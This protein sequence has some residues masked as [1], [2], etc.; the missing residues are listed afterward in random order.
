MNE[1]L[2]KL[3]FSIIYD[4]ITPD[5]ET[6]LI[7]NFKV[8]SFKKNTKSRNSIQRF[9]SNV[10]YKG[11]LVSKTIPEYF[12]FLLDKL[13]DQSLVAV[14]PESVTINEYLA[15]QGITPHIDSKGSGEVITVLSLLSS[16]EMVLSNKKLQ[17][18]VELP[19]RCL[20]QMRDE[21]RHIWQHSV[22]PVAST[23]YSIVFRCSN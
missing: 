2:A 6:E 16:A 4:F 22:K 15:G 10:P 20:C 1:E 3:G 11:S 9:G 13:I 14:K 19:P 18:T 5:Q 7:K 17:H 21:I 8:S 23:R 12:N